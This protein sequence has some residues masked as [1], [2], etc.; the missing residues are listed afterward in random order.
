MDKFIV[1]HYESDENPTIK[2]N[3]FDGL[4]VGDNREDAEEFINFVNKLIKFC[5]DNVGEGFNG[6]QCKFCGVW[7]EEH[8]VHKDFCTAK[9]YKELIR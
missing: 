7:I 9:Q 6:Q 3:G 4:I 5:D 8:T 2:G 1:K